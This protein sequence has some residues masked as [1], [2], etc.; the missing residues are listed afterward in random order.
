MRQGGKVISPVPLSV[1]S[2][3]EAP[4]GQQGISHKTPAEVESGAKAEEMPNRSGATDPGPGFLL[5]VEP[6]TFDDLTAA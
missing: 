6:P 4:L 2:L 3:S 1:T 5:S